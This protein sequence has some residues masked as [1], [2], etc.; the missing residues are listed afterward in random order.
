VEITWSCVLLWMPRRIKYYVPG[1][2]S[3]LGLPILLWIY[4]PHRKP[5]PRVLSIFFPYEGPD[6]S[7]Y[8]FSKYSFL[9]EIKNKKLLCVDLNDPA[10]SRNRDLFARKLNFI[11]QEIGRM[12]FLYDT[13]VVLKIKIGDSNTYGQFIWLVNQAKIYQV[14]RYT[15]FDSAFYLLAN[16]PTDTATT[17]VVPMIDL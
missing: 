2:I 11:S 1:V 14:K 9:Q 10:P 12:Q 13:S 8:G 7:R 15:F 3:L 17:K 5:R 16:R 4:T 6:A